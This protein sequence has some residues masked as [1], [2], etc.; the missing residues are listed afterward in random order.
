MQICLLFFQQVD[1]FPVKGEK[2]NEKNGV[3]G[4]HQYSN[5]VEMEDKVIITSKDEK[6]KNGLNKEVESAMT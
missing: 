1:T 3:N 5:S 6:P 4:K 2:D